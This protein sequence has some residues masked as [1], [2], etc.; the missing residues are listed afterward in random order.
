MHAPTPE[1][2][3]SAVELLGRAS[4]MAVKIGL[5]DKGRQVQGP[6]LEGGESTRAGSRGVA[7]AQACHKEPGGSTGS[8]PGGRH[9]PTRKSRTVLTR[10]PAGQ[11]L[12]TG[13][14]EHRTARPWH[15]IQP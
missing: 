1:G 4:I 2:T 7:C 14:T 5:P 12:V 13:R 15:I 11:R 6:E 9:A 3:Y 10:E 8:G